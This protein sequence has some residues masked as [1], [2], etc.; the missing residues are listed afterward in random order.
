MYGPLTSLRR[1]LAFQKRKEL[2]DEGSIVSGFV[3]FPAKL[4]M[5]VPG[6]VDKF[7]KKIYEC[8]HDY[9]LEKVERKRT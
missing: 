8:Y 9:S 4:M 1:N 2:K 5:N 3:K 6:H 7:G